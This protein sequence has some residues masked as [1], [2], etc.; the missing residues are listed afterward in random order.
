MAHYDEDT[1]KFMDEVAPEQPSVKKEIASQVRPLVSAVLKGRPVSKVITGK[2]V[3]E[4]VK[5][6]H[7]KLMAL[8]AYLND[9]YGR[10]WWDWEPETIWSMVDG[11]LDLSEENKNQIQALQV[12]VNTDFAFEEWHVFEKVGHAF[13]GNHVSFGELQPLEPDDAAWTCKALELIRPKAEYDDEVLAYIAACANNAGI[14]CMPEDL[15]PKGCQEQLTRIVGG[16]FDA[17]LCA[18]TG[19]ALKKGLTPDPDTMVGC[20]VAKLREISEYVKEQL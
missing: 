5:Q 1:Q 3:S 19:D 18:K 17:D 10:R 7:V 14:A 6:S 16:H 13:N 15:F 9:H 8:Y 4:L 2:V 11:I 12:V 20:Q